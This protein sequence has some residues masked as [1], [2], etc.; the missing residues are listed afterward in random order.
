M[1]TDM[2]T[3][4]IQD[5]WT[6]TI[7][8]EQLHTVIATIAFGMGL[9]C[10]DVRQVLQWAPSHD[11]GSYIQETGRCGRDGLA[12]NAVLFFSKEDERK[13]SP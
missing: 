12:P 8:N 4:T 9:D 5:W 2:D 6:S 7:N 3:R 11:I 13:T 10:P 1:T